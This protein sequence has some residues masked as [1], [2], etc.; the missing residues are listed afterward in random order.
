MATSENFLA[1]QV[2]ARHREDRGEVGFFVQKM[3]IDIN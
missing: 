3:T 2:L 1:G